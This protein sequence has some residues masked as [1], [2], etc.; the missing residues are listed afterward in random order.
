MIKLSEA[1]TMHPEHHSG[2]P[3]LRG[4]RIPVAVLL[5]YLQSGETVEAFL[6]AYALDREVTDKFFAV[7]QSLFAAPEPVRYYDPPA[8]DVPAEPAF[9]HPNAPG[10]LADEGPARP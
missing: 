7:L 2:A 4:T 5:D 1:V 6:D 8:A 9:S 3:C 10:P